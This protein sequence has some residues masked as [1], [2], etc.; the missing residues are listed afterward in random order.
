MIS[1]RFAPV[2]ASMSLFLFLSF[3]YPLAGRDVSVGLAGISLIA[4]IH[5][6]LKKHSR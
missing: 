1:S 2:Y 5:L 6:F 3:F 4:S